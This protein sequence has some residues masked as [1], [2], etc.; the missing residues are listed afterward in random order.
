MLDLALANRTETF[1]NLR[2]PLGE[3]GVRV[4]HLDVSGRVTPLGRDAPWSPGQFDVGWVYPGRIMEGAIADA[5]LDLPW[6]NDRETVLAS[7]N[8]AAVLARLERADIP[9]PA[10]VHVSNPVEERE[11]VA[12][13]ERLDPP[14]VVK[15]NSTTRG[16]G[17][18]RAD[19]LDSFLGIAEYLDLVHDYR[20]TGDK[21]FLLQEFVPEARDLRVMVVDEAYAGAVRRELPADALA[22]GRW[23]HNVHRGARATGV[24]PDREVQRLA[25]AV[26][27]ELDAAL[28]GVDVLVGPDGPVVLETNARPTVDL[29]TRY[30]PA[31]HDRLAD[32]VERT[33]GR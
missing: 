8:K 18:A 7:R 11:L 5:L 30:E 3:R 23:K 1:E 17:V 21:S 6:I 28:L 12:A 4:R 10:S 19:D 25:E 9:V 32:L 14:V 16:V 31:F 24:T 20:A 15:P 29:A 33:A 26:A 2:E 27:S 13:F 22:A